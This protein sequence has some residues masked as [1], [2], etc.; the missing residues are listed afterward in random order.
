MKIQVINFDFA[1]HF[2]KANDEVIQSINVSDRPLAPE[3][4]QN[5]RHGYP[6]DVWG[7][8]QIFEQNL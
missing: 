4:V 2:K 7:L 1:F 6:A 8:G 5:A 3:I